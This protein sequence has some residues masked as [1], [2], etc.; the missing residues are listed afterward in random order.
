MSTAQ[1]EIV[2]VF[3]TE[4][5]SQV[6]L[7]F[8]VTFHAVSQ[9][10]V[11]VIFVPTKAVGVHKAGVTSVGLV[12]ITGLPVPVGVEFFISLPVIQSYNTGTQSVA[13]AGQTT[14][15]AQPAAK[16][17]ADVVPLLWYTVQLAHKVTALIIQVLS[18]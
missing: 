7:A 14:S 6:E 12:L 5:T 17:G 11:P 18:L 1:A 13:E 10:A 15:Q 4:V 9:S 8:V 16:E 2:V 3:H